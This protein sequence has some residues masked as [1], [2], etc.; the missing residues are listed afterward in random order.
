MKALLVLLA[1][2]LG[3]AWAV[4]IYWAAFHFFGWPGVIAL[5]TFGAT[6]GLI[7]SRPELRAL[8]SLHRAHRARRNIRGAR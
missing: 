6:V 4:A 8:A 3:V 5:A 1:A 2:V 7:R